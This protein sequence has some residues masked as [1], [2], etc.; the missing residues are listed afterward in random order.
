VDV[1]VRAYTPG[2]RERRP[3]SYGYIVV[4]R[5]EHPDAAV[6]GYV[7]EHRLVMEES[8]GRRLDP[9]ETVH[10]RNGDRADNRI[11]NLE[12]RLGHHGPGQSV[13]D[14]I[15][16]SVSILRRYAPERLSDG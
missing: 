2:R 11:E 4:Y 9:G 15:E 14:L 1:P 13:D 12:L 6:N 5:P 16:F 7:S 10:H 3:T 8:L